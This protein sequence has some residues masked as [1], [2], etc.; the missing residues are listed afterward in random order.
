MADLQRTMDRRRLLQT[1]A[2][3][4]LGLIG[5]AVASQVVAQDG[6]S[7]PGATP[8]ASP[9]A[10]PAASPVSETAPTV[11]M[12]EFSFDPNSLTV[13]ADT[14]FSITLDN[15][16]VL[17]HDLS[18][19]DTSFTSDLIDPGTS[20]SLKINLPAGSYD[21]MCTVEGHEAAGMVGKITAS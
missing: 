3:T 11:K 10:S 7:T 2:V 18:I 16:G 8:G 9:S 14:D 19:V 21:F 17:A 20:G 5:V 12:S 15:V 4:G 6:G 13:P 1:G